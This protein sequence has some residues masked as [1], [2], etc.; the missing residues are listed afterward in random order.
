[1]ED[2]AYVYHIQNPSNPSIDDGYIGVVNATKGVLRRFSEHASDVRNMRH[3]IKENN[4]TYEDHVKII[5][6]GTLKECY[7]KESELRPK[8][9]MGWNIASGG[10]GPYHGIKNLSEYRSKLQKER[11]SNEE[12]RLKQSETFRKRY[13][14]DKRSQQIRRQRAK[15][16]MADPE[17][18][19]KCVSAMHSKIKCPHCDYESNKGNVAQHIKRKHPDA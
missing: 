2:K 14:S 5:F 16:H 11:M 4:V 15:E 8:Q 7:K 10:G 18:R 13:Y 12:L 17:M 19:K 1:M 3:L 6:E 9:L